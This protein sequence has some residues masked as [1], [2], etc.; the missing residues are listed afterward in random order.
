[1]S[2]IA[3]GFD[4]NT[5]LAYEGSLS[6]YGR[7]VWPSP[8]MSIAC[9]V[10]HLQGLQQGPMT[11]SLL[12]AAMLFREDS[13]DPVARVRRGRL[14]LR[15]DRSPASWRVVHH[16]AD[17]QGSMAKD[18]ATFI[19]WRASDEFFRHRSDAVLV[20]GSGD[21]TTVHTIL[22]VERLANG[23][24]LITFRTRANLSG[25]PNLIESLLPENHAALI[26]EQYEKAASSAFRDDAESVIDRCREAA[27]AALNAERLSLETVEVSNGKDLAK[28]AEYFEGQKRFILSNSARTIALLHSRAKSVERLKRGTSAPH[29]ADAELAIALLGS[30]YREM[31]WV[32]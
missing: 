15:A 29:Q 6:L 13:F 31:R 26:K 24:E 8:F 32:R 14:Y 10:G 20:L 2:Q 25:L 1:M 4:P 23:E 7:L 28:L 19:S 9:H 11:E 5:S 12:G 16:V 27:T 3:I 18:L 22:D 30:I 21:R 17:V